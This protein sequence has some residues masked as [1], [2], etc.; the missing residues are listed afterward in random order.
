MNTDN[1][2][3][4]AFAGL[5]NLNDN[6]NAERVAEFLDRFGLRWNVTKT[7]LVLP[8]GEDT[9]YFGIVREDTRKTFATCKDSYVPYQNSELA[10]L[11]IRVSEKTG[12]SIH[13]GGQFNGGG[14]VYLQ[15][16][17][18]NEIKDLGENRTRVQG[19][20]TGINS[21]DGTTALKWGSVNFTICCRN[22]FAAASRALQNSAKHTNS[23]HN[24][25][26]ESIRQ[27][28]GIAKQEENIFNSFMN[29]ATIPATK[30]NIATI[31]RQATGVDLNA[32]ASE[33]EKF[34]T[35][36]INRAGELTDS[37]AQEM[38]SKGA[39]L[40]GLFSGVTHYTSH[41]LPT[42]KRDNARTESK[43]TGSALTIDNDAYASVLTMAGA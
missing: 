14:K 18:G 35:Y 5:D 23:M 27:I 25:I 41:K 4:S 29:F 34:S 43:Y 17:T 13:S 39:T 19:F 11:L 24:R 42:P 33:R 1:I 40:W 37:I 36:A 22:T 20:A 10:E 15:L 9:G 26:E 7:P 3:A 8:T 21:H 32:S 30:E 28:N 2:I 38:R 16:A 31:V 12:Y 6:T